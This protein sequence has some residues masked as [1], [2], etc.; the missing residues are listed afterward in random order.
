MNDFDSLTFRREPLFD[1]MR[2][3]LGVFVWDYL[4]PPLYGGVGF[5]PVGQSR[6]HIIE[7]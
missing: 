7:K 5:S 4:F 6:Q 1:C 2:Y 3:L